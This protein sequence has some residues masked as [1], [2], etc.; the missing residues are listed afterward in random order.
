MIKRRHHHWTIGGDGD[1]NS[2]KR[3]SAPKI[4]KIYTLLNAITIEC[5]CDLI[6]DVQKND[7]TRTKKIKQ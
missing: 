3:L 7:V 5:E 2:T 6:I 1:V 4:S